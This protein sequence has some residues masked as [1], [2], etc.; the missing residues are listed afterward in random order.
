M[1]FLNSIG[2]RIAS[3]F[4]LIVI[5]CI[6]VFSIALLGFQN[7]EKTDRWNTHTYDVLE[8]AS[9]M[10]ASVV[11]QETGVRGFLVSGDENFLEPYDKGREVFQAELAYLLNKTS[12]NP[13]QQERLARLGDAEQQWRTTIAEREIELGMNPA[14]LDEGRA[15]EASGAGKALM[16]SIRALHAEF[17]AAERSLL[18][19]RSA[20][21]HSTMWFS[22]AAL[23]VGGLLILAA[24]AVAGFYLY[25]NIAVA[26]KDMTEVMK[27]LSDGDLEIEVPF[28][29]R[30][31]ELG[32]MASTVD[33]FLQ[34]AV[35]VASL[36]EE[37]AARSQDARQKADDTARLNASIASV[38]EA[39]G[40]GDFTQH[41]DTDF[42]DNA[43]VDLAT[44]VNNLVQTV[45][46]GIDETGEVLS[47]LAQT[48]LTQRVT[49]DYQGAFLKL[50]QDTNAVADN[51]TEIVGK[52]RATSGG[53]K[54]ATGEILAGANDLSERT[55]RQAATIEET[56]AAME[57]LSETVVE[58]TKNAETATDKSEYASKL[59]SD[60]GDVMNQTTDAME[61]ITSSSSKIS[62]II[63]MIDDI[64]FQTNLLALNASVEAARAGE[65]GKGFA[66]V[67]IE[68]RRL[69]QSAAEASSEV[70]ALIEQSAEEVSG[71]SKLVAEA[72]EKLQAMLSVVQE[73]ADL[74]SGISK[75]SKEQAS[76]IE[77][78]GMAVRQMDE[79]TQHNAALV[80]ETN[81]AIEQTETQAN[82]LDVIVDVFKLD[83]GLKTD[84]SMIVAEQKVA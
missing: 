27:K 77:E 64:A 73:N 29:E 84:A 41:V 55:T 63:G 12:D 16:D 17:D 28:T 49:G 47:A 43:L 35:R 70:K 54:S 60:S 32:A 6:A 37:E 11:D 50:K 8:H 75:A 67:A 52:L 56:S 82:D 51:L 18:V 48:D 79:M 31:D 19:T 76:A 53:L 83:E 30:K 58:N 68:V 21:K 14:T 74:M 80:E 1:S 78:V 2:G 46:R 45:D 24:A 38:I 44:R 5:L 7:L 15:L 40:N 61:R 13:A 23:L 33:V 72:S 22:N 57:Q 36:G 62:N 69:A 25:R 4:G 26:T 81:A 39:A 65:A 10:M 20:E 59:A 34:N 42:P 71:G 3:A 9:S 66:V